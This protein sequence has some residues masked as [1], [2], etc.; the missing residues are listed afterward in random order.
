[1]EDREPTPIRNRLDDD[2]PEILGL[3]EEPLQLSLD[4]F[5]RVGDRLPQDRA[6]SI[7]APAFW[8]FSQIREFVRVELPRFRGRFVFRDSSSLS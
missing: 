4:T 7:A 5:R 3:P 2:R 6:G 8:A 1:M